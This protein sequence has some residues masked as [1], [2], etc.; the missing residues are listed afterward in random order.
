MT[1]YYMHKDTGSV[2]S[3]DNWMMDYIST[4]EDYPTITWEEWE[5]GSLVEV[6][7]NE[8]NG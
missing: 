7:L 5:G 8:K 4:K 2:D 6:A 3:E 1:K